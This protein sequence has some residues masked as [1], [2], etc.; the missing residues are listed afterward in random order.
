MY[1]TKL[2]QGNTSSS[3]KNLKKKSYEKLWYNALRH[4]WMHNCNLNI[5]LQRVKMFSCKFFEIITQ[6]FFDDQC[7]LMDIL[8]NHSENGYFM[9]N[10]YSCFF[11]YSLNK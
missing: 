8:Q 1:V 9:S 3:T 11:F 7:F 4:L 10:F 6:I 5:I 2:V